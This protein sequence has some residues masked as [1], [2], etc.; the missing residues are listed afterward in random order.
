MDFN[1]DFGSTA[2]FKSYAKKKK[3]AATRFDPFGGDDGNEKKGD[4]P[5]GGA[6]GNDDGLGGGDGG[7]AADAGGGGDENNGGNDDDD[8]WGFSTGKKSKKKSKKKQEEEE[9]EERKRKE[10]EEAQAAQTNNAD[11]L[12]WADDTNAE[13]N[14]DWTMSWGG[15]KNKD[16][17]KK[18]NAAPTVP[19][20]PPATSAFQD[21][22]LDDTAPKL[23]FSFDGLSGDKKNEGGGF[24]SAWGKTWGF[25]S[26]DKEDKKEDVTDLGSGNPWG[27]GASKSKK[28]TTTS[29]FDFGDFST[30]TDNDLTFAGTDDVV[31]TRADDAWG[32]GKKTK[33]KGGIEEIKEEPE[34]E[35][36]EEDTWGG[37]GGAKKSSK[38]KKK[39][40]FEDTL[41]TNT[42]ADN[43]FDWGFSGS[44]DKKKDLIDEV[45]ET[46]AA[47]QDEGDDWMSGAWGTAAKKK[48]KKKADD[49]TTSVDLTGHDDPPTNTFDTANDDT[50][51]TFGAGKKDKKKGKKG[52]LDDEFSP[53][54]EAPEPPSAAD[55]EFEAAKEP[56]VAW[57]FGLNTR[58]KKKKEKEMRNDHTWDTR[59]TQ[60]MVDAAEAEKIATFS[61]PSFEP[62]F[63]P[64][65]AQAK[66]PLV[67]WDAGLN[68][69]AQ[70][71]KEKQMKLDGT[72]DE[73][74]TQ[75]M[76]DAAE[77]EAATAAETAAL[78]PEPEPIPEPEPPPPPPTERLPWDH[79]LS[80]KDRRAKQKQMQM[81][82][83]W[84]DRLT[85]EKIDQEQAE[86]EA[87]AA[88]AIVEPDLDDQ[89][90]PEQDAPADSTQDAT[91]LE[92]LLPWDYMLTSKEKKKK[93]AEMKADG[94]W[95]DRLTQEKIDQMIADRDANAAGDFEADMN[96]IVEPDLLAEPETR[97]EDLVPW[98]YGLST[99][100]KKKREKEMRAALTWEDRLTQEMI[101]EKIA[102]ANTF[103]NDDPEPELPTEGIEDAEQAAL[104][105]SLE[106]AEKLVPWDHD[107]ATKDRKKKE[108]QMKLEGTW[109][110]RL[111]QEM[112]NERIAAAKAAAN[113]H[114]DPEVEPE[115]LLEP[116]SNVPTESL[117]E[118]E[119]L[120][121][122][123]Q[124][125]SK[126]EKKRSEKVMKLDGT[127]E[128]RLT[129]EIIDDKIAAAKAAT[130]NL[131]T[132]AVAETEPEP[133]SIQE[134]E[135]RL[136]WDY[137]LTLREKKKKE[138]EMKAD[139]TWE[140]RLTQERIDEEEAAA[141]QAVPEPEAEPE[142][143]LAVQEPADSG[144][145]FG[146][147]ASKSK[148]KKK[149]AF[150]PEPEK[151]EEKA[152]DGWGG[153]WGF[154][155]GKDKKK[156]DKAFEPEPEH[157]PEPDREPEP[158]EVVAV[159][160]DKI[161]DIWSSGLTSKDKKKK[162]KST[163]KSDLFEPVVEDPGPTPVAPVEDDMWAAFGKADKKSTKK[164][165]KAAEEAPP[166]P[167]PSPP[168]LGL[169][170][171]PDVDTTAIP[172]VD[173]FSWGGLDTGRKSNKSL[174]EDPPAK[175]SSSSLWGFGSSGSTTKT[176]K[177]KEKE[178]KAQKEAEDQAQREED[179]RL[180]HEAEEA[181]AAAKAEE[182]RVAA[183][184]EAAKAAKKTKSSKSSKG[185]T[186]K[187]EEKKQSS[188]LLDLLDEP[189]PTP[190]SSSSKL[191][192]TSTRGSDK[193]LEDVVEENTKTDY[194][195][196]WDAS[197]N[198]K[199]TAGKK[200]TSSKKEIRSSVLTNDEDALLAELNE[201]EI[202]A[203]LDDAPATTSTKPE[204]TMSN[205]KSKVSSS[206]A[207]R[208]KALETPAQPTGKKSKTSSAALLDQEVEAEIALTP[209]EVKKAAKGKA[210]TKSSKTQVDQP[211]SPPHVEIEG[212]KSKDSVPGSFP[213]GFGDDDDLLIDE[214]A[215]AVEPEAEKPKVKKSSKVDKKT[216]T[217]PAKKKTS[218]A[219][220]FAEPE[221]E[222]VE[223]ADL[224]GETAKG[225]S[226]PPESEQKATK[227]ERPRVERS[228]TTSWGFWSAAPTPTPKK[229]VRS[230]TLEDISPPSTRNAQSVSR[231]KS[232]KVSKEKEVEE[233]ASKTSGSD[234][235]VSA[236]STE[237]PKAGRGMGFASFMLGA[238]PPS[239]MRPGNTERRR[240]TTGSKSSSRR[241]SMADSGLISPPPDDDG[242]ITSKAAKLMGLT[243]GKPSRRSSTKDKSRSYVD[244]YPIDDDDMVMINSKD[245][246]KTPTKSKPKPKIVTDV[247]KSSTKP[248]S[249]TISGDEDMVMVDS[250]LA[251]DSAND[252]IERPRLQ[253][254]N[255]GSKK[256]GGL[257]GSLFGG[258]AKLADRTRSTPATDNEDNATPVRSRANSQRRSRVISPAD[259]FAADA[260]GETDADVV[261][262]ERRARRAAAERAEEEERLARE[263][264]R[265]ERRD[266]EKADIEARREKAREQARKEREAEESRKEERRARRREKEVAEREREAREL[267]EIEAAAERRR[268]ERRKLRAQLE[269][270]NGIK[271]LSKDDRRRTFAGEE[272]ARRDINEDRKP[273]TKT[274]ARKSTPLMAEYHE[275]RSGSG[276]GIK[277]PENKTSSWIDSQKEEPPELPPVEP[278]VLDESGQRARP[279]DD[280]DSERRRRRKDKYAGM[281]D[282]EI[283]IARAKRKERRIVEK[284][285]SGGSDE[286]DPDRKRSSKRHSKIYEDDFYAHADPVKTYDGRPQQTKRTSF[287]GKFF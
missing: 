128:S 153:G 123:D 57:D 145:S 238:A 241:Q 280:H 261:K 149:S 42:T 199:K 152:E 134:A 266:R 119:K 216:T 5:S 222:P 29:S 72:W 71:K 243:S 164:S 180:Q 277:P 167:V 2:G 227:K 155:L 54:P 226:P 66:E 244:P 159:K 147:G 68:K 56:L 92:D 269:A 276:R 284:S 23:D 69:S 19:D 174:V 26:T 55:P 188:D 151:I 187:V 196:F 45:E 87:A 203:I 162:D 124:G 118:L 111:T 38:T 133:E 11:P 8:A 60:E 32:F 171:E 33:K 191:K 182:E 231:S 83:T 77:K 154:G 130:E 234:K 272:E 140:D 105:E 232:T 176:K 251:I 157:I 112:I 116:E 28:K 268:E 181:E 21:I 202:Q 61:E 169:T 194:F 229:P 64:V 177:E 144:W 183:E 7:D 146:W 219:V 161:G 20:P 88:M 168:A 258:G 1:I 286:K 113:A 257:F 213:G 3:A 13:G 48:N 214:P 247:K 250:P 156:K 220:T 101:D 239:A 141:K 137:G 205:G 246:E 94:T 80:P 254:S 97:P 217:R 175:K 58:E 84:A 179:E 63:E 160:E 52:L 287:L 233:K 245:A 6:G 228:A 129:Q 193:K 204:K 172:S 274:S 148:P 255:T 224:L 275:S 74:V 107:V 230:K 236:K 36:K 22:S 256:V 240:S 73:R 260:P 51:A 195:N 237:R 44:K 209:K 259:G 43:G 210:S 18:N 90:E 27:F 143:A 211:Y 115:T 215:P 170:P 70:R 270:E 158:V 114:V 127:W 166:P 278:T 142:P 89:L 138:K 263:Q 85:Q 34:P 79:G 125:M 86:A 93:Q 201:D 253:R 121:P 104:P 262:K 126:V 279:V 106:E 24:G 62:E 198:T 273:R 190:A 285:S 12:S 165:K 75:E 10:E 14:E 184:Q 110:I 122:W 282:D 39:D 150:E 53:L 76:V 50:W 249:K 281:T 67:A 212:K 9:E 49:L 264:R 185:A 192:K 163:K 78:E 37:W 283:A 98:D 265:R 120:V 59:V 206:I 218:E 186:P 235:E 200:D 197:G 16:K 139:N 35:Q 25:N 31:D 108:R 95:D 267:A 91:L 252:D 99:K 178:A 173:D 136:P 15:A 46:P 242:I 102:A 41:S 4:T 65:P 225:P 248:R 132:E 81:D 189:L 208:I 103:V 82:N 117:E 17:K 100:E 47:K 271:P 30:G 135:P 131:E 109:E 221:L 40:T 96:P 207:D 223:D